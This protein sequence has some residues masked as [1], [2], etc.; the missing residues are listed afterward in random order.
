MF[1]P[2]GRFLSASR[3]IPVFRSCDSRVY[4]YLFPC[5]ILMPPF[6]S[7]ALAKTVNRVNKGLSLSLPELLEPP[8][9]P[10]DY[11]TL[12]ELRRSFRASEDDIS[13]VRKLLKKYQ[14]THN[15][16]NYTIGREFGDRSSNRYMIDI[17]ASILCYSASTVITS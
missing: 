1:Q 3:I 4:E 15:F 7:S 6:P 13:R 17:D 8:I 12:D 14:G 5:Y 11:E 16:H 9:E 2:L 10:P